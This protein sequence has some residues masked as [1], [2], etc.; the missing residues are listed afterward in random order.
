MDEKLSSVYNEV[1][2]IKQYASSSPD[3]SPG[4]RKRKRVVTRALSVS[5]TFWG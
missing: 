2:K 5:I 3:S 1:D 4:E